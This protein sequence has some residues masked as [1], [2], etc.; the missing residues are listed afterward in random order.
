MRP[1]LV[2]DEDDKKRRFKRLQNSTENSTVQVNDIDQSVISISD[3][4]DDEVEIVQDKLPQKRPASSLS[5]EKHKKYRKPNTWSKDEDSFSSK[6]CFGILPWTMQESSDSED[7]HIFPLPSEHTCSSDS[8]DSVEGESILDPETGLGLLNE[9]KS[10]EISHNIKDPLKSRASPPTEDD[11]IMKYIHKKFRK[12][13]SERSQYL[14]ESQ[15][16]KKIKISK[17]SRRFSK[18]KTVVTAN[19]R[20]IRKSVIVRR[21]KPEPKLETTVNNEADIEEENEKEVNEVVISITFC[22]IENIFTLEEDRY[23]DKSL[24]DF[25]EKWRS[26]P[27][28]EEMMGEYIGFCET[29]QI[30]SPKFFLLINSQLR[31]RILSFLCSGEDM[32][33]LNMP[34]Q[35]SILKANVSEALMLVQVWGFNVQNKEEELDFVF[36]DRDQE[37]FKAKLPWDEGVKI[38]EILKYVPFPEA[39]KRK[40]YNLMVSCAH[41]ILG[42]KTVFILMI[43]LVVFKGDE[44]PLVS[45][46][47]DQ[48]WTMLRRYLTRKS[49]RRW[50]VN[51][52]LDNIRN[53]L[54]TLPLI[55][56]PFINIEET[57]NNQ[58]IV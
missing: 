53:C 31:E 30:L 49:K 56:R 39:V 52:L 14:D 23:F 55:A 7:N 46:V 34:T 24:Q 51:S 48:Y 17:I 11:Q 43:M 15:N 37:Q 18:E 38:N 12:Y 35:F 41:P 21:R 13:S 6:N 26:V 3:E 8:E 28:G 10:V 44:D 2:L 16:I 19:L 22:E 32:N 9:D 50:E 4:E 36:S 42:D 40:L 1:D 33:S 45:R 58:D 54:D 27:F 47:S 57:R 25:T 20:A 5:D 29:R